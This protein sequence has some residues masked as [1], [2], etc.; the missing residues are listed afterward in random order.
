MIVNDARGGGGGDGGSS[1]TGGVGGNGLGGGI[2]NAG[3][4]IYD[5]LPGATL[6]LSGGLVVANAAVGGAG[7]NGASAG[8]GLGGGLYLS[9]GGTV[10]LT[11]TIVLG[12]VASTSDD[13][14]YYG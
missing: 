4:N 1:G 9:S 12:N 6:S 8:Q 11:E 7:G 14:I 3:P 13:N 2:L 5:G 10:T